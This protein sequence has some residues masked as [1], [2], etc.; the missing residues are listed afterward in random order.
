MT[1]IG[2]DGIGSN[3][4][5]RGC[6]PGGFFVWAQPVTPA[7][8]A[9]DRS[10]SAPQP[11]HVDL[12]RVEV[13]AARGQQQQIVGD[14]SAGIADQQRQEAIADALAYAATMCI[15]AGYAVALYAVLR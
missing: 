13:P 15:V 6:N 4:S 7:A 8:D 5:R 9:V 12:Q 11:A 2:E 1:R 14:E 3:Q 10:A